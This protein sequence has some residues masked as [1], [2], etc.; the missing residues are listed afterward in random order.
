MSSI[1]LY[2]LL[3]PGLRVDLGSHTFEREAI[4][5]FARKFDP[6]RFHLSEEGAEGTH[7]KTLCAS[8]WHTSGQWMKLN[9]I[10]G[11][12][13]LERATG[14]DG[15]PA[16]FGP[17]PGFRNLRWHLPVYVGDTIS[18]RSTVTGKRATPKRPGWGMVLNKAEGFNQNGDL[19]MSMDGAVTMRMD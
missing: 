1:S 15:P 3:E 2:Y 16:V 13:A 12:R 18:Y 11:R 9:V 5:A 7:F 17:S 19:V 14:Y 10:N 4:I 8:G 6:Q